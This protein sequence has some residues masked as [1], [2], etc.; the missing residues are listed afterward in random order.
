MATR[1][2]TRAAAAK[3]DKKEVRR[4][5]YP[6]EDLGSDHENYIPW[7][8]QQWFPELTSGIYRSREAKWQNSKDPSE[9]VAT[10]WG[11]VPDGAPILDYQAMQN[12]LN[13][14]K[15]HDCTFMEAVV[16]VV[17][18]DNLMGSWLKKAVAAPQRKYTYSDPWLKE[19][20]KRN[21]PP[22]T[23]FSPPVFDVPGEKAEASPLFEPED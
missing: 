9:R 4:N 17:G 11:N 18:K 12:C 19:Q 16:A 21:P 2:A 23:D 14:Q 22:K 13:V 8:H 6:W 3:K 5:A 1:T 15:K 7:E 10:D 20:A